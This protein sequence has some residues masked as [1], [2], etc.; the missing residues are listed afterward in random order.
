MKYPIP[1]RHFGMSEV[2]AC[3]VESE[4]GCNRSLRSGNFGVEYHPFGPAAVCYN[5]S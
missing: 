1:T 5:A 2:G 3:R 4:R